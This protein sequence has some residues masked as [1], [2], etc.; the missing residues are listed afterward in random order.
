MQLSQTESLAEAMKVS[1]FRFHVHVMLGEHLPRVRNPPGAIRC[2]ISYPNT[3][4]Q[5]QHVR[6]GPD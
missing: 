3:R 5:L 4:T 6:C 1:I 2:A